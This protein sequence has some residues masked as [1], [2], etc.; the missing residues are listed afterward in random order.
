MRDGLNMHARGRKS[1]EQNNNS[2][3]DKISD[4]YQFDNFSK[5]SHELGSL[6]LN[7]PVEKPLKQAMRLRKGIVS[8]IKTSPSIPYKKNK[9]TEALSPAKYNPNHQFIHR[10]SPV[11][12]IKPHQISSPHNSGS[13]NKYIEVFIGDV[14]E[15]SKNANSVKRILDTMVKG[16]NEESQNSGSAINNSIIQ[17]MSNHM[18]TMIV[19]NNSNKIE[20]DDSFYIEAND[21]N[22]IALN[23]APIESNIK[24]RSPFVSRTERYPDIKQSP[25]PGD[26]NIVQEENS[27][28]SNDML[29]SP[30]AFGSTYKNRTH[31]LNVENTPFG[32][33]SFMEN[34]GVGHYYKERKIPKRIQNEILK[35]QKE[36]E[37]E[38]GEVNKPAFLGSSH[39]PCL[40]DQ[41]I[42]EIGPGKYEII[43]GMSKSEASSYQISKYGGKIPASIFIST[44]PRFKEMNETFGQNTF[45][46]IMVRDQ[47]QGVRTKKNSP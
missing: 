12:I 39:R 23:T 34:P 28:L 15:S 36:K 17:S 25:G 24:M 46:P 41:N 3:R 26:Y 13:L 16:K 42:E 4:T 44:S 19:K 6:I 22:S 30:Q 29:T 43:R 1:S 27:S 5:D 47:I 10:K 38:D 7:S 2:I 11:T 14:V 40:S 8:Q 9:D 31:F 21:Y 37:F 18:N 20:G 35:S 32:D 45:K 33:P